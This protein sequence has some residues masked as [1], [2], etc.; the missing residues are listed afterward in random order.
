LLPDNVKNKRGELNDLKQ[1][2]VVYFGSNE[3]HGN[4]FMT[5]QAIEAGYKSKLVKKDANMFEKGIASVLIRDDD[6]MLVSAENKLL[7]VLV[8]YS[9]ARNAVMSMIET[10][11]ASGSDETIE[12]STPEKEWLFSQLTSRRNQLP[13]NIVGPEDIE[14][15]R[16]HLLQSADIFPRAISASP[17]RDDM[18][19]TVE[20]KSVMAGVPVTNKDISETEEAINVASREDFAMSEPI[21]AIETKAGP[22]P[23]DHPDLRDDLQ[24]GS[25]GVLDC[26]FT[27]DGILAATHLEGSISPEETGERAAQDY[28][29]SLGLVSGQKRLSKTMQFLADAT[30][31]LFQHDTVQEDAVLGSAN[32]N[33]GAILPLGPDSFLLSDQNITV[34]ADGLR[35][36][37]TKL[38]SEVQVQIKNVQRLAEAKQRLSKRLLEGAHRDAIF[39]VQQTSYNKLCKNLK[40]HMTELDK[41]SASLPDGG[42]G[43]QEEPYEDFLER[44]QH[45]WGDLYEDDR[46]WTPDDIVDQF[47]STEFTMDHLLKDSSDD[48]IESIEEFDARMQ[49]DWGWLEEENENEEIQPAVEPIDFSEFQ[50]VRSR[51]HS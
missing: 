4:R 1:K 43:D 31:L 23:S 8:L 44:L 11:L 13:P 36:L 38:A 32:S 49:K 30:S 7:R 19:L 2:K 51:D 16:V 39:A 20:G 24:E 48:D 29:S 5:D 40:H 21:S 25:T 12:W 27:D 22:V 28:F 10:R 6:S 41:W 14:K 37:C 47:P 26:F 18:N 17:L 42:L 34:S 45:E 9:S 3:Y 46:M 35:D 15:L 50:S 33:D